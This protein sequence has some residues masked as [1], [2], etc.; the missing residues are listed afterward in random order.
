[1]PGGTKQTQTTNQSETRNPY[2]PTIGPLSEVVGQA[3]GQLGNTG[4]NPTENAAFGTLA[5]NAQAGNPF[6]SGISDYATSALAGGG[7][8]NQAGAISQN[9]SNYNGALAPYM[10]ANYLD[11]TTNPQLQGVL[12]QIRK[13]VGNSVNSMFAGA[14]RDLSGMNQQT[15]AQGIASGEAT[16]LLN[17]Y[18]TNV[19]VQRGAQDASY[20]AGNTTA[21][22]LSALQQQFLANQGAGVGASQSALTARDSAANQALA[23]EAARR[24]LPLQNLSQIAGILN[25]IAALGGTATGQS[26]TESQSQQ[27]L[28]QQLLGG[29]IGA[30]GLAGGMNKAGV[31]NWGGPAAAG[32]GAGADTAMGTALG[33]TPEAASM[34]PEFLSALMMASDERVKENKAPVGALAD[35]QTIWSYN[36]KG[37]PTPRIGLMAQEVE[38]VRPDAVA[39]IGGIKAVNYAKATERSRGILGAL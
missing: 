9:L 29:G 20:G 38:R 30:A 16:P 7:A 19:G 3:A 34:G 26:T 35:G 17:Q 11:P 23:V 5:S 32:A 37:D 4:I 1:M 25:P 18:N 6:A 8:N 28:W 31:F 14:G 2:G 15:L 22:I 13:D 36:Y 12:A 33:M 27:P 10:S 24:G 21:G 39:E